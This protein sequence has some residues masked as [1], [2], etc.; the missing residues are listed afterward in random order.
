M[1]YTNYLFDLD[2]VL[3]DSVDIQYR[4]T[5]DAINKYTKLNTTTEIDNI[6]NSTITTKKKLDYL[7]EQNIISNEQKLDIYNEKKKNS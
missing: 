5:I 6:L 3:V 1:F 4:S 2:G 7:V